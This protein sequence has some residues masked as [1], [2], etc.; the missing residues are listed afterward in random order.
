MTPIFQQLDFYRF[1][2]SLGFLEPFRYSVSRGNQE[3]GIIQGFIQKDGGRLKRFLS[4][5]AIINGGPWLADD[6]TNDEFETLLQNCIKGLRGMFRFCEILP[7]ADP[8]RHA[9]WQLF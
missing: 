7:L 1:L 3:V 2:E 5:R 8:I 4:R 6:I 9:G